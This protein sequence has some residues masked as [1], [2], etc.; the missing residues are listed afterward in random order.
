MTANATPVTVGT[1]MIYRPEYGAEP[2]TVNVSKVTKAGWV[3]FTYADGSE[4]SLY[5]PAGAEYERAQALR[6][7][8]TRSVLYP[9]TEGRLAQLKAEAARAA[10]E[11]QAKADEDAARRRAA[12]ER[13]AAELAEVKAALGGDWRTALVCDE[14]LSDGGRL[15]VI[16][17]PMPVGSVERTGN[18]RLTVLRVRRN[19]SPWANEGDA[20][21]VY[22]TYADKTSS[23][24][25]SIS[26]E[27]GPDADTAIW[28]A[29]RYLHNTW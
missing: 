5:K 20:W 11:R 4:S 12:E 18:V 27:C 28:A 7:S 23:S 9:F 2:V 25:P 3:R 16:R 1:V 10:A 13:R 17:L 24:F 19:T 26:A 6:W 29:L 14:P 22:P 15:L 21:E 8:R